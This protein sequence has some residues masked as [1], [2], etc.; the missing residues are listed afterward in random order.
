MSDDTYVFRKFDGKVY[1]A[2]KLCQTKAEAERV[3]K[4]ARKT[5]ELARIVKLPGWKQNVRRGFVWLVYTY[6][7]G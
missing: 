7:M 4:K 3:A 5:G 1:G 6:P 2:H